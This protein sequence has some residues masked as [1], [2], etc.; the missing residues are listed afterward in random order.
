MET[1]TL[2]NK[3]NNLGTYRKKTTVDLAFI[4]EPFYV[5]TQ[6]GLME[7]SPKTV[8]DWEDGY[9]LSYPEDGSKP[10]S[11]SPSFVRNNYL[12]ISTYGK[13]KGNDSPGQRS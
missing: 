12:R 1:Y 2:D 6:E 3:P 8:D 10:Y 4:E 13:S 9:Y 11:I 7:I 5:E